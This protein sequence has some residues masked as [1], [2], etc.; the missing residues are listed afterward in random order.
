MM[1][2]RCRLR[3]L[4]AA[5]FVAYCGRLDAQPA[6]D[7]A[8]ARAI[9]G[10]IDQLKQDF[11]ARLSAL[12]S[13]LA[14][15]EGRQ[16][17]TA[18]PPSTAAQTAAATP[19]PVADGSGAVPN[20]GGAGAGSKI[21]NPD[22][23]VIGT[24]LGVAGKNAVNPLPAL[25]LPESEVSLQ[26][27]VDPYARADFFLS[28][29]EEGV[30]V[31]EGY[32]TF[33]T[34]PGGL[35]M[36]VGRQYAAFGK[37]NTLHSHVLPW[38]DRPLASANLVGGDEPMADAGISVARLIPNPWLFLEA[39]GQV[40]RGDGGV[41]HSSQRRD[42]SYV[43]HVRGYQDLSESTNVDFGAS[44]AYGHNNSGVA[45]DIDLGRFTTSLFGVDGTIRWRPLQ[46]AIYNSF[47]GRGEVIWSRRGQPFEDN[48]TASG[49][50]L[51]GDYQFGRRWF[52]GLRFDRSE[53]AEDSAASDRGQSLVLTYRPSEFSQVRG[54]LRRT[55]YAEGETANEFLFQF[56]F[57]I[58]AHGAHPF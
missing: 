51:S 37:A 55:K 38:A 58:G 12:E 52:A 20:S 14:A 56:Q 11:D 34:L 47:L 45:N 1:V 17:T 40:F 2:S 49:F 16:P 48:Q 44:Y 7:A 28:F 25:A 15:L 43:G 3:V 24:F 8:S 18:E 31:E 13:R 54:Q 21:F 50:Y 36:K 46:R 57:A 41:F 30:A 10:E 42:L 6:Q 27:V 35:L 23:A 4:L 26:A 9:R 33:P 32:L 5:A 53:R 29:G 22:M 39:T 19:Q